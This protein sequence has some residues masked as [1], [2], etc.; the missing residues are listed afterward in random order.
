M[1]TFDITVIGAGPGGYVAAFRAAQLGFKTALIEKN[2][3]LGGT[4]LNIGCIPSKALLHSTEQYHFAQKSAAKHGIVIGKLSFD[5]ETMLARKDEVVKQLVGGVDFLVKKRG[6]TRYE[7][8]G[9][10]VA[11]GKIS[12]T[13]NDGKTE[14]I[15]SKHIILATGS[16]PAELPNLP[17]DGEQVVTSTE[18]LDFK[19][20]PKRLLVIGGGAIGLELGSVW[21]R[22]GSTVTVVEFLPRIAVGVDPDVS[23]ALQRSLTAQGF[24]FHLDTGVQSLAKKNGVVIAT[25]KTKDGKE[26]TIEADKVLVSVGRKPYLA[27]AV[28]ESL[29]LKLTQRGQVEVD[30]HYVTNIPGLYAIGDIIS[31]P[32]LAH[33]AEDEGVAVVERIAGKAGHVNYDAI[34]AVIYTEPEVAS[35]GLGEAAAK[36]QGIA[37]KIGKFNFKA[38][39]RAIAADHTDGY[40]KIIADAKNDRL[41]GA[42]IIGSNASEL[43]AE[44]VS[45]LEFGGSAEDIA[46]TT[47]SHPTLS[48]SIKE[49]ALAVD[50][51]ALHSA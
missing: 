25:A 24:T 38:N 31:G 45:V 12:V 51:R 44:I 6:I 14:E 19:E 1:P 9:K 16:V 39:G 47:H 7:G 28:D 13:L 36:E 20:V 18:A 5:L 17:L 21:A 35:V 4:C 46:R 23:T 42:Q 49:A 11:P 40:V 43:L 8:V 41:L 29:G 50:K 22:L 48:E 2:K 30:A 26:I 27:G 33:K 34:P 32:M 10:V 15:E 37:V 3:T